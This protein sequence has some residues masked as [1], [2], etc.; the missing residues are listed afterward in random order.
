MIFLGPTIGV[1]AIVAIFMKM[2][3]GFPG[4]ENAVGDIGFCVDV[5]SLTPA[6]IAVVC[7]AEG[8]DLDLDFDDDCPD[9]VNVLIHAERAN[10]A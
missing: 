1:A 2:V 3:G 5:G 8:W 7:P 9:A 4:C 6:E 10:T